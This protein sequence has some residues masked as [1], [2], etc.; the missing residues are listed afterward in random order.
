VGCSA[1][2][3]EALSQLLR[4][5]KP[6]IDA[7]VA[8]VQHLGPS[9][10]NYLVSHLRGQTPLPLHEAT[11][12]IPMEYGHV[13]VA[14]PNYHLL[15]EKDRTF[16][17]SLEGRVNFARPSIDVLFESAARAFG[18]AVIAVIL[19]GA[20]RD[21]SEG[22]REVKERG[23]VVLVQD[24]ETAE[25]RTMPDAAVRSIPHLVAALND[26]AVEINRLTTK[27]TAGPRTH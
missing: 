9:M 17:L 1:G 25:H 22:C 5:I 2:G 3:M 26:L 14:P 21:G 19:T 18:E 16:S 13:Y 24:P 12:K 10:D 8:I 4:G 27:P 23:G 15:V 6:E 11:D 20:N 7:A